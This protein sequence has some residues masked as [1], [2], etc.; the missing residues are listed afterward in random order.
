PQLEPLMTAVTL[1]PP[2]VM[3]GTWTSWFVT[4]EIATGSPFGGA[5]RPVEQAAQPSRI[6][7]QIERVRR[8]WGVLGEG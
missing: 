2:P 1:S 5:V 6:E 3:D 7:L 4:V 8:M